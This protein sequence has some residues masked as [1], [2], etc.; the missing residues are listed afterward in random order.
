ML[1]NFKNFIN[2][3]YVIGSEPLENSMKLRE[4]LNKL[5]S[6]LDEFEKI[7]ID[8]L[9]SDSDDYSDEVKEI[10][11]KIK[12]LTNMI[13]VEDLEITLLD[14]NHKKMK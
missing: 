5:I 12:G 3:S 14:F 11:S 13:E 8:E 2:E 4:K 6:N 7:V 9:N 10:Q 1:K